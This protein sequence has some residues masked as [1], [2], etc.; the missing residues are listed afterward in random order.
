MTKIC[1]LVTRQL[2]KVSSELCYF[3]SPT[4]FFSKSDTCVLCEV[5]RAFQWP[6]FILSRKK[7]GRL[8]SSFFLLPKL[9]ELWFGVGPILLPKLRELWSGVGP[10]SVIRHVSFFFLTLVCV[11]EFPRSPRLSTRLLQGRPFS[12]ERT[13]SCGRLSTLQRGFFWFYPGTNTANPCHSE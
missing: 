9:R 11:V 1:W 3:V 2:A 8:M 4:S 12:E 7:L 6:C 5:G 10:M 13:S